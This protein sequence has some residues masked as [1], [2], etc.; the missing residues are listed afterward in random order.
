MFSKTSANK[1]P[2]KFWAQQGSIW[3]EP[4]QGFNKERVLD[5]NK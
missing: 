4:Q 2:A 1:D 5:S 3:L